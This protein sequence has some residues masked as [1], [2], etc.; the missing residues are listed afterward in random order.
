MDREVAGIADQDTLAVVLSATRLERAIFHKNKLKVK[1]VRKS[2]TKNSL[3]LR[4]PIIRH[5]E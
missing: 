2:H 1:S 5:G 4:Y 3:L